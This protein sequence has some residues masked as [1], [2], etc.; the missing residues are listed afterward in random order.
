M[1]IDFEK[2][3]KEFIEFTNKY[4][5][6][7]E[8]ISRKIGHSIRVM[9]ISKEIATK[10][11]LTQEEIEV[12]TLIG[13]L[14]DIARFEQYM[15][16]QTFNDLNSFDHGDYAL[17]ILHKDIRKYIENDKYDEIIR[18]A[19]KNHNK[20]E[21]E[22][23]L[24]EKELIFAKIIRDADK[25]DIIYESVEIFWKGVENQINNTKISENVQKQFR[26]YKLIKIEKNTSEEQNV[27]KVLG[28]LAFIFDI[29]FTE[30]FKIIR[31]KDYINKIL[32]RFNFKDK[33]TKDKM[34]EIKDIANKYIYEKIMKEK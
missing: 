2:A 14:H 29:N 27:D 13:L 7:N 6:K 17:E 23:R 15:Q 34:E 31:N 20:F 28:V 12:A 5:I 3:K 16:F 11:G 33:E 25:I 9:N 18:K 19:I 21:I 30:S 1:K 32:Y 24:T 22:K 8:N 4:D 10:I 26:N